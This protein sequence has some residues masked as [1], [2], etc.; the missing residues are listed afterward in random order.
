LGDNRCPG[1]A[2]FSNVLIL[3]LPWWRRHSYL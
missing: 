3:S 2:F 1:Q